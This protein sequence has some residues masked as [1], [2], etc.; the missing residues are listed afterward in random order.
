M[1]CTVR[2]RNSFVRRA[3]SWACSSEVIGSRVAMS[4]VWSVSASTSALVTRV[5]RR[6]APPG[7]AVALT[8]ARVRWSTSAASGGSLLASSAER[9]GTGMR[10]E[11]TAVPENRN[12]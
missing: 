6:V 11:R 2:S 3:L 10:G 4:T 9:N 12:C 1:I 7:G 5:W 8:N